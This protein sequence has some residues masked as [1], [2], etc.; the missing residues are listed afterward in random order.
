MEHISEI[1][2]TE[3]TDGHLQSTFAARHKRSHD[4]HEEKKYKIARCIHRK[5]LNKR[6]TEP[7]RLSK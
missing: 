6:V 1:K 4:P 5:W 7:D 3:M 2:S